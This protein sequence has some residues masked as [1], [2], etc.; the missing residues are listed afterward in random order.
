MLRSGVG[1]KVAPKRT[2]HDESC[3]LFPHLHPCVPC[4]GCSTTG[5]MG[6]SM[7]S[8]LLVF[9]LIKI[10]K[11]IIVFCADRKSLGAALVPAQDTHLA[12]F[13]YTYVIPALT[14]KTGRLGAMILR[15]CSSSFF[16]RNC[17]KILQE[18]L[19]GRQLCRKF[20]CG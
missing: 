20:F 6:S 11:F 10:V 16:I 17:A 4:S 5:A 7:Y 14:C 18:L 9:I 1:A 13:Q 3:G 15:Y 19:A 2:P 8:A 12:N